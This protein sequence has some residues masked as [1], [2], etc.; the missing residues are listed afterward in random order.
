VAAS[1]TNSLFKAF[2]SAIIFYMNIPLTR[3]LFGKGFAMKFNTLLVSAVAVMLLSA[4]GKKVD[5]PGLSG[6]PSSTTTSSPSR[7]S[8]DSDENQAIK[9]MNGYVSAHNGLIGMFYSSTK[10][11]KGLLQDYEAQNIPK[12]TKVDAN[13]RLTMYL[14]L[15]TL[16]NSMDA[17]RKSKELKG[18]SELGKLEVIA[19]RLLTTGDALHTKGSDLK[20]YFDSKKYLDDN[21]GKA[22]TE[23]TEF[24]GLWQKLIVESDAFSDELDIVER[25]R[26]I[27]A[28]KKLRAEGNNRLAANEEAMLASSEILGLFSSKAD[29]KNPEKIKAADALALQLEKLT[30]EIKTETDKIKD[31][32]TNSY[33][34]VFNKMNDFM[35]AYRTVKATGEARQFDNMVSAYNTAV[36]EQK[37]LR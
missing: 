17:L 13:T 18:T 34:R 10:G 26:R 11:L 1:Q 35:G 33:T 37:S 22:K 21:L 12:K 2:V 6:K 14:S 28:V 4:C 7:V 19:D 25:T 29:F 32:K 27:A 3:L 15:G 36:G 20:S 5:I 23:H 9:K 30:A 24:V 16:K 8:I 31:D